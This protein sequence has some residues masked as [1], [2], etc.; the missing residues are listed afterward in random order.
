M[1]SGALPIGTTLPTGGTAGTP[2][3]A[4]SAA[5]VAARAGTE[6]V[7]AAGELVSLRQPAISR[8]AASNHTNAEREFITPLCPT[9]T[10]ASMTADRLRAFQRFRPAGHR[11]RCLL[12]GGGTLQGH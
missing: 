6:V 8:P 4:G 9:A 7:V 10:L 5:G 12:L 2:A 3:V 1:P 11:S